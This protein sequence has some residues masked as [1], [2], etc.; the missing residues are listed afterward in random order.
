MTGGLTISTN[1]AAATGFSFEELRE[2]G[3]S[4]IEKLSGKLWTDYNTHDPGITFLELI[5]YAITDL[6]YRT[7]MPVADLL[8]SEKNND[9]AMHRQF[10][11]ALHILPSA[12]VSVADYRKILVR[13]SG[14]KNAWISRGH[15]H[16]M[17]DYKKQPTELRYTPE[18]VAPVSGKEAIFSLK[19]LNTILI[20]YDTFNVPDEAALQQK[21]E[22]VKEAVRRVYHHFRNLCEDLAAV[23][24]VPE[25]EIVICTEIELQPKADPEQVYAET[26]FAIDQYLSPDIHFYTLPQM[27]Q[28]GYSSDQIFDGPVYDYSSIISTGDNQVSGEYFTRKGFI[29]DAEL[30]LSDLKRSVRLSDIIRVVNK[31]PGVKLIK[32]ISFGFCSCQE[33]NKDKVAQ[34]FQKDTWELCIREGHKPTL[35]LD[36]SVIN[37]YKDIIPIELKM[38]EAKAKVL[39]VKNGFAKEQ[40][41]ATIEDLPMPQGA[42]RNPGYYATM[43]NDLPPVYGVGANRLPDSVSDERKAQAKQLQAYLLFFDQVLANYFSQLAHV[44]DLLSADDHSR[45]SYFNNAVAVTGNFDAENIFTG[46]VNWEA[47][48]D[49]IYQTAGL[50]NYTTRKNQFLDHLL[51]RFNE[52]FSEY[53]FLLHRI[54]GPDFDAAI[55]RNKTDFYKDYEQVSTWRGSAADYYNAMPDELALANVSGLEKRV[56]RLLGFNN[57]KRYPLGTTAYNVAKISFSNPAS[58][59]NWTVAQNGAFVI[60]GTGQSLRQAEAYE[61]LGLSTII[62]MEETAYRYTISGDG[63]DAGFAITGADERLAALSYQTFPVPA[64]VD[65]TALSVS[66]TDAINEVVNAGAA[67]FTYVPD[68]AGK[69]VRFV[70]KNDAGAVIAGSA[71]A[72]PVLPGETATGKFAEAEAVVNKIIAADAKAFRIVFNSD[73]TKAT[74]I[75][76]DATGEVL[77]VAN[78]W[79]HVSKPVVAS[80]TFADV[81]KAIA[82]LID[83]FTNEFRLEGMYVVENIL[84]RPADMAGPAA[85]MPVC[86]DPDGSYCY[87]LDPYS[88][89]INIILPGYTLRLRNT[90][91]RQYAERIIRLETPAH[92]LAR[93]CFVDETHMKAFEA[94]YNNWLKAKQQAGGGTDD[95]TVA[96][97][98]GKLIEVVEGL[99]TVYDEGRLSDCNDDTEEITPIL[100]GQTFLGTNGA[101]NF[102]GPLG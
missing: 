95:I 14:V 69:R 7:N 66:L 32:N 53:V 39:A 54:Y 1:K 38:A 65:I 36:N 8:A 22:E 5:C 24:E 9:E 74:F 81:Q 83:Y 4:Y 13:I 72:L 29:D 100:L 97:L 76:P 71:I 50:D 84:L 61:E 93:I 78:N 56:S 90:Y 62:G 28:K 40:S 77:L 52:Q 18:G 23:T 92:V 96:A 86:M 42:Y 16:I 59:Y 47:G 68:A 57:Y 63:T 45:K 11:S 75:L 85:F 34:S 79:Y 17:A 87:P 10:L 51:A 27:Q 73:F 31:V 20:E 99:F 2:Q 25:Q 41:N 15:Q 37:F 30:S 91:F 64:P 88:F 102:S 70:L 67:A 101:G 35:C 55:I 48:I 89:R 21:Q 26:A 43:Q 33:K 19:G 6:G 49:E 98:T 94:A 12:P 3:L 80:D 44:K 60:I 58:R 46:V 82:S